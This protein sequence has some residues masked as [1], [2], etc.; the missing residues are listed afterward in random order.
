MPAPLRSHANLLADDFEATPFWWRDTP[1]REI[2]C[3]SSSASYDVAIVGSGFTGVSAALGLADI[4][5][6]VI[7]VDA[8]RIGCGASSRNAGFVGKNLKESFLKLAKK[9]GEDMARASYQAA[10]DAYENLLNMVAELGIDCDLNI[11]G[12]LRASRNTV[13][14]SALSHDLAARQQVYEEPFYEWGAAQTKVELPGAD[15]ASSVLVENGG[16]LHPGKLLSSLIDACI[17][18]GVAFQ[19]NCEVR[20][21]TDNI[22]TKTLTTSMGPINTKHVVFGINGF[23]PEKPES[24]ARYR[25]PFTANMI[26]TEKLDPGFV[27]EV[28]PN[29]RAYSDDRFDMN[30]FRRSPCGQRILFGGLTGKAI[31]T[32]KLAASLLKSRLVEILPDLADVRISNAWSGKC[33]TTVDMLPRIISSPKFLS[34]TGYTF[35]GI[36]FGLLLGQRIAQHLAMWP[37][38]TTARTPIGMSA[39]AGALT[40]SAHMA[41]VPTAF[42]RRQVSSLAFRYFEAKECLSNI[43][44]K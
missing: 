19:S 23:G 41:Y 39:P 26:A 3:L 4:G 10:D 11:A 31:A 14:E 2:D 27:A 32:P 7:V 5:W 29:N 20:G 25:M 44:K 40:D 18:R 28:L 22:T 43:G 34:A 13:G 12:R 37:S 30:Y 6:N 38:V 35:T 1:P 33:A 17:A 42:A 16:H 24:V 9:R 36:C 15:F 21:V 8:G